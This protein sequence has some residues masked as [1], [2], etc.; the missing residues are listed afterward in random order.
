MVVITIWA[1]DPETPQRSKAMVSLAR[2]VMS[3]L[4]RLLAARSR[5][6]S[7]RDLDEIADIDV[8]IQVVVGIPVIAGGTA[9]LTVL[10]GDEFGV[11]AVHAAIVVHVAG[12]RHVD[13]DGLHRLRNHAVVG[14][15]RQHGRAGSGW[16]A[17]DHGLAVSGT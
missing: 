16:C 10:R 14:E 1:A 3:F 2:F 8:P 5:R 11:V 7:G 15:D 17:G 12:N 9:A 4:F 6:E 13:E